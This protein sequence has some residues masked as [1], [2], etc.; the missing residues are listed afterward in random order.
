[1]DL[2]SVIKE[3]PR[4]TPT[5]AFR[6]AVFFFFFFDGLMENAQGGCSLFFH[7]PDHTVTPNQFLKTEG[8]AN[9]VLNACRADHQLVDVREHHGST[10][11]DGV[12]V[13]AGRAR[14][15]FASV[16]FVV[17]VILIIGVE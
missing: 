8:W 3:Q 16:A 4:R 13:Q 11:V 1:M 15:A 2:D 10:A 12:V 14:E 6:C 7:C 9:E 5:P 17:F